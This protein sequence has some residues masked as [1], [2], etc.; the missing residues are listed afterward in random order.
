MGWSYPVEAWRGESGSG[1]LDCPDSVCMLGKIA[2]RGTRWFPNHF[3]SLDSVM[4][5]IVSAILKDVQVPV[6]IVPPK[7]HRPIRLAVDG[8]FLRGTS[9]RDGEWR[10]LNLD[11]RAIDRSIQGRSFAIERGRLPSGVVLVVFRERGAAP[12]VQRWSQPR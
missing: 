5:G 7:E 2:V 6:S 12:V 8:P 1:L 3:S 9:D 4:S 10:V 11:G